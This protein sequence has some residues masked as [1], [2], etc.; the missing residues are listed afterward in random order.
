MGFESK[1]NEG[2]TGPRQVRLVFKEYIFRR[3]G[4]D[5]RVEI[6]HQEKGWSFS[7]YGL[8]RRPANFLAA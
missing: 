4:Y 7:F 2:A 6:F 8:A 5:P 3:E 1:R